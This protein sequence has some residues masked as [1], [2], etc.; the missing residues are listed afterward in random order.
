MNSLRILFFDFLKNTLFLIILM[1][2]DAQAFDPQT[3]LIFTPDD[4]AAICSKILEV[5]RTP[6][7]NTNSCSEGKFT[8]ERPQANEYPI[9]FNYKLDKWIC[10]G[11][12]IRPDLKPEAYLLECRTPF[13]NEPSRERI[14]AEVSKFDS[15]VLKAQIIARAGS[16]EIS[17]L[18]V[19]RLDNS[20][21][22]M[23][24]SP[25]NIKILSQLLSWLED[26]KISHGSL[27][28]CAP[29][30]EDL[31]LPHRLTVMGQMVSGTCQENVQPTSQASQHNV[32]VLDYL[33]RVL[34]NQAALNPKSE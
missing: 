7:L 11:T 34:A 9:A 3:S 17:I 21:V 12:L 33:I 4:K 13:N 16:S 22:E 27:Q 18:R 28:A 29:P 30:F 20:I 25:N 5:R 15:E 19:T 2:S 32:V 23:P 8:V 14:F 31:E 6:S 1:S 26:V 24:L 10:A